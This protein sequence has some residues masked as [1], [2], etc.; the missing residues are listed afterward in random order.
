MPTVNWRC[1]TILTAIQGTGKAEEKFKEAA[2]AYSVLS[3]TQKRA[4]YDRFG[5]QGVSG[6]AGE[7]RGGFDESQFADFGDILGDLFGFGDIFGGGGRGGRRSRQPRR[8]EDIRY[9]LEITFEDA[10]RGMSA[11][12]QIPRMEACTRCTGSG[13]EPRRISD[14]RGLQRTR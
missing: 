13:A 11:D 4:A 7:R 6:G 9:D 5:H 3:D 8:G 1:S 2:E 14:L 10:M 12:L